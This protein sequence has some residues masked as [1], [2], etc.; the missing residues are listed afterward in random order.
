MRALM[1]VEARTCML[2]REEVQVREAC[3]GSSSR[4]SWW[5]LELE[6]VSHG[7]LGKAAQ[8]V[9]KRLDRRE[10]RR[11]EIPGPGLG[12]WRTKLNTYT[13]YTG[14]RASAPCPGSTLSTC[15]LLNWTHW[16]GSEIDD[17]TCGFVYVAYIDSSFGHRSRWA[18]RLERFVS[19]ALHSAYAHAQRPRI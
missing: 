5:S 7:A 8:E 19:R 11:E 3:G 13:L 18:K 10:D 16:E 15:M 17:R 9:V 2:G 4:R 6:R 14:V 12:A 1:C